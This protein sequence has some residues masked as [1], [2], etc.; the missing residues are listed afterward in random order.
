M[1]K[2]LLTKKSTKFSVQTYLEMFFHNFA[3][4]CFQLNLTL[5]FCRFVHFKRISSIKICKIGDTLPHL[6]QT[7]LP[8]PPLFLT[9]FLCYES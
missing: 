9:V 7:L 4:K 1:R 3:W 5:S 6:T 2:A 8:N